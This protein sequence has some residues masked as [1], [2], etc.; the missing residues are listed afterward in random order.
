MAK[1]NPAYHK[2]DLNSEVTT[3]ILRSLQGHSRLGFG[4]SRTLSYWRSYHEHERSCVHA[5]EI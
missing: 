5:C 4:I 3:R 1:A 2:R